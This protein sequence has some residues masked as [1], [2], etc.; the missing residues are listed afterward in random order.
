MY[1]PKLSIFPVWMHFPFLSIN[2]V[3]LSWPWSEE[4]LGKISQMPDGNLL[5]YQSGPSAQARCKSEQEKLWQ[6]NKL[7]VDWWCEKLFSKLSKLYFFSSLAIQKRL[8]DGVL[9]FLLV[10]PVSVPF[11]VAPRVEKSYQPYFGAIGAYLK[12]KKKKKKIETRT[13]ITMLLS[14]TCNFQAAWYSG[15]IKT[16]YSYQTGISDET[17]TC[18]QTSL[19]CWVGLYL[20]VPAQDVCICQHFVDW[21]THLDVLDCTGSKMWLEYDN[22]ALLCWKV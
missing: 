12:I 3:P 14:K 1:S 20:F 18:F 7:N 17:Q 16:V 6:L 5:N 21:Y 11:L 9:K 2:S 8:L 15:L 4:H 13:L 10:T 19:A 22:N